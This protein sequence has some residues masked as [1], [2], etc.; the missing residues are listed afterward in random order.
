MNTQQENH[1][2]VRKGILHEEVEQTENTSVIGIMAYFKIWLWK[3][4]LLITYNEH[5]VNDYVCL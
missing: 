5:C 4:A 3:K 2:F 1:N